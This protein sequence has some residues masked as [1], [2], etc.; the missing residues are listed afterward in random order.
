LY[1]CHETPS[2]LYL[3]DNNC[4]DSKREGENI[5]ENWAKEKYLRTMNSKIA[6]A[7]EFSNK[8]KD[9]KNRFYEILSKREE[10]LKEIAHMN[11]EIKKK[12]LLIK[13]LEEK[14]N[15]KAQKQAVQQLIEILNGFQIKYFKDFNE[16]MFNI[17]IELNK[18]NILHILL[19]KGEDGTFQ[20]KYDLTKHQK[21]YDCLFEEACRAIL[22][23]LAFGL[24]K[25]RCF[26]EFMKDFSF[27]MKL[28]NFVLKFLKQITEKAEYICINFEKERQKFILNGFLIKKTIFNEGIRTF[29][30]LV[31]PLT[32]ICD[33]LII[34][35]NEERKTMSFKELRELLLESFAEENK[36]MILEN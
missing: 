24:K 31:D 28:L 15:K 29:K 5:N 16:N 36:E 7:I 20:I 10:N 2:R 25:Y 1:S 17:S 21:N 23:Q 14:S 9:K 19:M 35:I 32:W 3:F 4:V 13:S 6:I 26:Y 30:A 8:F 33:P 27:S 22:N 18:Y 34:E 12:S 11:E